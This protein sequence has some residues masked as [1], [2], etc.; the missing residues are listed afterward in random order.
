MLD[1]REAL[2]LSSACRRA[3]ASSRVL[4]RPVAAA[5]Q[6][7][8]LTAAAA[9]AAGPRF[10]G[11]SIQAASQTVTAL[12]HRRQRTCCQRTAA[13]VQ[14][15]QAASL[16]TALAPLRRESRGTRLSH[17]Q[18]CGLHACSACCRSRQAGS[19]LQLFARLH[20][21]RRP[22]KRRT[23]AKVKEAYRLGKT[24]GTGGFA[25]VKLATDRKSGQQF[26][27]KI[28]TLPPADVEPGDNENSRCVPRARAR[29]LPRAC[30]LRARTVCSCHCFVAVLVADAVATA[31]AVTCTRTLR[32]AHAARRPSCSRGHCCRLPVCL[33]HCQRGHIQGD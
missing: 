1:Q 30:M 19:L 24:L 20:A 26:A 17:R 2:W 14:R 8:C 29:M 32:P 33:L 12:P 3:R 15:Q 10:A 7:S 25:I 5:Q 28:M 9:A 27:V 13:T 21:G 23:D 22:S 16:A 6:Y 31:P 4:Q 11:R 18:L